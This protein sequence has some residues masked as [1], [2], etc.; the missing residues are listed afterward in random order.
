MAHIN[1]LPWRERL[2]EE[3]KREF[4]SI[5]VGV[6]IIA[7]GLL[8]LVDRYFF[9]GINTQNARNDFLRREISVLD[10]RVAEINQLR[11]QKE[12]IRARMNVITDL[13]GTRP[14]IVRIFDEL[15]KTMPDGVY[16]SSVVRTKDSIA[17][18]GISESY[19]RITE[20]MRRLDVSDWFME[21]DLDDIQAS[22]TGN[23][24]LTQSFNFFAQFEPAASCARS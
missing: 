4:F 21:T 3:R 12:D 9:T 17:I 16:Y 1:L 15:V 20:L 22:N 14:V 8:F 10:E 5:I 11:Q 23:D 19:P 2:R 18:E 7:A 6:V 13:Q 24:P